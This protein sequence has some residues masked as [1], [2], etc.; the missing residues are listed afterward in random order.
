MIDDNVANRLLTK[1]KVI[2]PALWNPHEDEYRLA[3]KTWVE[4]L[5][6]KNI[7]MQMIVIGL[8]M[9]ASDPRPFFPSIGQFIEW[10]R[11]IPECDN[12]DRAY[13][14]AIKRLDN[15]GEWAHPVI[16]HAAVHEIGSHKL[17]RMTDKDVVTEWRKA[18][19]RAK[20]LHFAGELPEIPKALPEPEKKVVTAEEMREGLEKLKR[21]INA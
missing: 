11:Y 15:G 4:Y 13:R 12:Y 9:A 6:K 16:Y 17:K 21:K 18:L 20:D 19:E 10:C 8:D 7:T 2:K 14:H 3:I 5:N 1:L